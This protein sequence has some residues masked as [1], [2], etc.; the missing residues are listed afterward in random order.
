MMDIYNIIYIFILPVFECNWMNSIKSYHPFLGRFV[1]VIE[2]VIVAVN[3]IQYSIV[4][5]HCRW[6]KGLRGGIAFDLK[7]I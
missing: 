7:R 1:P 5:Y 4:R 3:T 6:A 2:G